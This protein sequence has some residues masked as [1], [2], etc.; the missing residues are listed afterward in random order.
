MIQ[1]ILPFLTSIALATIAAFFSI[2][3]LAQIFP[4]SFWPIVIMGTALEIGKLVTVSWLY[5]NWKETS[6]LLRTYFLSAIV[7]IMLI[8]SMGIFGYLSKAHI[9]SNIVVGANAVQLQTIETQEKIARERLDYLLKQ[10]SDPQK[11]SPRVDRDIRNTQAELKRLSE[12]KLPLLKQENALLAEIG[13]IKYVAE[14]IYEK[15]DPSFI[16]KAVRVVILF[17]IF[18]FDPLAVLL[19]VAANQTYRKMNKKVKKLDKITLNSVQYKDSEIV[20]KSKIAKMT[21]GNF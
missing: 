9:E 18:V 2:I 7:I 11:T 19:L 21:G 16:D 6:V 17:I 20:P 13:P 5:N 15:S 8:T 12:E 3:G 4:G 14:L 10:A 1:V